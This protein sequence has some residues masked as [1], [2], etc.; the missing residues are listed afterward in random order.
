M[1]RGLA[2]ITAGL[3]IPDKEHD[4]MNQIEELEGDPSNNDSGLEACE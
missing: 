1:A 3:I 4:P 2:V